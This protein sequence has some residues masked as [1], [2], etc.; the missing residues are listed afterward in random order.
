[1]QSFILGGGCFWC[2]DATFRRIRGVV[3]V[4]SGYAGGQTDSPTY[5]QVAGGRTGHAEVV[6][7]TFNESLLPPQT[8]LDIFFSLHDPTTLNRQGADIGSQ[9]RSIMLYTNGQQRT[10]FTAAVN[11]ASSLWTNPVV[12]HIE[13]LISF[14]PAESEHQN[15]FF[16]NS[17]T[18]Y[19]TVVIS[20]KLN[21]VRTAFKDYFV[22]V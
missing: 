2:L 4:V 21:K 6:K 8:L 9:Y 11:R 20:P 7:V 14:Y 16:H 18:G 12:T 22:D 15:Y 17:S 3:D 10:E 1:M 13:P 19:C 5:D